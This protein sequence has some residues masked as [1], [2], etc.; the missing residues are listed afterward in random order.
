MFQL[1]RA[2]EPPWGRIY[3]RILQRFI[4]QENTLRCLCNVYH[5]TILHVI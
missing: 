4:Q 3:D 1:F 5:I 2:I